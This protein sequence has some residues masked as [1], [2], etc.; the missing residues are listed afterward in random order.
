MKDIHLRGGSR[1]LE[2]GDRDPNSGKRGPENGIWSTSPKSAHEY[3]PQFIF[4]Y[5]R[6][7][8]RREQPPGKHQAFVARRDWGAG[9]L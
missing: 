7:N 4:T 1:K 8:S 2:K 9:H 5:V 3:I 6:V